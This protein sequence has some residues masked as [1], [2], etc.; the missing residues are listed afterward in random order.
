MHEKS[1]GWLGQSK[2]QRLKMLE[3]MEKERVRQQDEKN[4][5]MESD[6]KYKE[7]LD[8]IINEQLKDLQKAERQAKW[9]ELKLTAVRYCIGLV[10][11][12][13]RKKDE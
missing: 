4:F 2:E 1:W 7:A 9:Y 3:K 13:R 5:K 10:E 11:K 12:F 6:R 8:W